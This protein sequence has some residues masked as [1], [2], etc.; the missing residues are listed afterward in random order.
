MTAHISARDRAHLLARAEVAER[1]MM[2]ALK[3]IRAVITDLLP[4][5]VE[6]Y[7]A[8]PAVMARRVVTVVAESLGSRYQDVVQGR[9]YRGAVKSRSASCFVLRKLGM[10]WH[11]I[12]RAINAPDHSTARSAGE[13][14]EA[15][16]SER[17]FA[18]AVE[19]GL[20]A[21]RAEDPPAMVP[22]PMQRLTFGHPPGCGCGMCEAGRPGEAVAKFDGG[23]YGRKNGNPQ[24]ER[25]WLSPACLPV[26][27]EAGR[28]VSLFGGAA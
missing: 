10:S 13:T 3:T 24:R 19:A 25:L 14:A 17:G 11:E 23:G 7:R 1:Q 8:D 20:A 9:R 5:E 22:A 16:M 4:G 21:G 12:A 15:R 28:Q 2:A 6:P 18:A 27:G 26:E